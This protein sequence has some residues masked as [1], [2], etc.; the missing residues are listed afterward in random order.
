MSGSFACAEVDQ[1]I[2]NLSSLFCF[3]GDATVDVQDQGSTQMKHLSIGDKVHVGKSQYEPVY[4]FGHHDA[5]ASATFLKVQTSAATPL[6]VSADHM[7]QVQSRGFV[8]ASNLVQGDKLV[9][10][11]TGDEVLVKSIRTVSAKGVFAPFTPSGTIVVNGILASSFVAL[12]SQPNLTILGVALSHQWIAH[13]FEFPHRLA[14]HYLSQCPNET[15][16]AKGIS[17]WVA[18]PLR[19]SQWLLRQN[20]VVRSSLLTVFSIILALFAILEAFAYPILAVGAAA[21]LWY[22][23]RRQTA[24]AL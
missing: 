9:D 2:C 11:S 18:L 4:S 23:S 6:L 19:A 3:A 8:P 16:T 24:K 20:I 17:T 12:D 14:C 10:G 5:K 7:V 22:R 15:Y 13:T 21:T 1:A